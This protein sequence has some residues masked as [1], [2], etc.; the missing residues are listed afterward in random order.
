VSGQAYILEWPLLVCKMS[1]NFAQRKKR[2]RHQVKR[3]VLTLCLSL[4]LSVHRHHCSLITTHHY[5][6]VS[7]RGWKWT[8]SEPHPPESA[9]HNVRLH[10]VVLFSARL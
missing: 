6:S 9:G 8:T 10:L 5:V 1:R 2:R 3:F 7:E 4:S